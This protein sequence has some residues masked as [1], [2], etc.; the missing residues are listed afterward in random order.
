MIQKQVTDLTRS[1]WQGLACH[2]SCDGLNRETL[3]FIIDV[4]EV[5]RYSVR[6][7]VIYK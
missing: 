2:V 5:S 6:I 7:N 3:L 1:I 4:N